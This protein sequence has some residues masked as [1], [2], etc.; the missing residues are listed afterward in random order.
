MAITAAM[1]P[2]TGL[3]EFAESH[4]KQ[5]FDVGIA[6]QHAVCFAAGLAA[7]GIRPV[8]AIYSTFLQRAYDQ[9][10]HD[11]AL[12]K[13]PVIFAVDRGGLVGEDGPTHHGS[14]D[15]SYLRAVP[16]M[17]VAVPSDGD[18][19]EQMLEYAVAHRI[20]P[21][22]IRYPRGAIPYKMGKASNR[23]EWGR[24]DVL[25]GGNDLAIIAAGSMVSPCRKVVERLK[26]DGISAS[27]INGRFVKPL[28][29][30]TLGEI[31]ERFD[32]VVSVEENSVVGGFGSG[33]AAFLDEIDYRG[34]MLQLGIPDRFVQ[35][36]SRQLLL[37]EIGLDEDGIY[38]SIGSIL[39]PKRSLFRVLHLK[40]NGKKPLE[41]SQLRVTKEAV[42][43]AAAELTEDKK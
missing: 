23:F 21:V 17:T 19:L 25:A 18:E 3:S 36:G 42:A 14:F 28:D 40:R 5:F 12:Q 2:G 16:N 30:E 38:R 32:K 31:A 39:K 34:R 20:G 10:I 37:K 26:E 22:A 24:W 4:P 43:D 15:L 29:I 7:G 35:H 27:L 8:C 41:E 33:I 13:L 1:A 6:E 9:I 11:V